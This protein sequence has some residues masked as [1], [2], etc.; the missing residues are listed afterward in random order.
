MKSILHTNEQDLSFHL[1]IH[2]IVSGGRITKEGK[3]I[4]EKRGNG[5]FLFPRRA[6]EKIYKV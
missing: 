5:L 4:K 1:H 3:L 6:M 2:N